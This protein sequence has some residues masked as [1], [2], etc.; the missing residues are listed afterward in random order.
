MKYA[1]IDRNRDQFSI[2]LMC[3]VLGVS[4]S[5]YYAS[6]VRPESDRSKR[7]RKL[8]KEIKRVHTQS[9]GTYGS[10]RI[11]AELADEGHQAGRHKI[12]KLM[13]IERLRGIPKRNYRVTTQRDNRHRIAKDQLKQ[14]FS[15]KNPNERW[16]ADMTAVSTK[17]G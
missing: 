5:G 16:V 6:K 8:V 7:D 13:R 2:Q 10:P 17:Q 15:A 12:A 3:R 14:D 11:K 1:C 9:K 4:R